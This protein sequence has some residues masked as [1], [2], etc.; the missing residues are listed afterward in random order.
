[1]C[2]ASNRTFAP[3]SIVY[4]M[5]SRPLEK[6]SHCLL[7]FRKALPYRGSSHTIWRSPKSAKSGPTCRDPGFLARDNWRN[8]CLALHTSFRHHLHKDLQKY[9]ILAATKFDRDS[10]AK[11]QPYSCTGCTG[12]YCS[13]SPILR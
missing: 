10:S 6:S 3:S 7:D 8:H 12:Q 9:I 1:M 13:T 2:W 5:T 4:S 11:P